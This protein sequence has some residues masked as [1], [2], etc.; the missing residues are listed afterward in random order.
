MRSQLP[1]ADMHTQ[2]QAE[3]QVHGTG[4]MGVGGFAM[5]HM[6]STGGGARG[7]CLHEEPEGSKGPGFSD[8]AAVIY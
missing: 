1:G 2:G 7:R 5:C 3:R 6:L 4:D 8:M